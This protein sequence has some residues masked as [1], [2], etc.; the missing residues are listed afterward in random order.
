MSSGSCTTCNVAS[1]WFLDS[2]TSLCTQTCPQTRWANPASG[3]CDGQCSWLAIPCRRFDLL[4]LAVLCFLR[5]VLSHSLCSP[6]T[7]FSVSFSCTKSFAHA[8]L[9]SAFFGH[10]CRL[11][12]VFCFVAFFRSCFLSSLLSFFFAQAAHRTV[13]SAPIPLPARPAMSRAAGSW[14]APPL[15]A[16]RPAL[17]DTGQTPKGVLVPVCFCVCC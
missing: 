3:K 14:T 11:V 12:F 1:G 15:C 16:R 13:S 9:H 10:C 8:L 6:L 7:Y 4:W 2:S 5:F 17:K